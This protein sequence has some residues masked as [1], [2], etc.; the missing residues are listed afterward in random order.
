[1]ENSNQ[2][3]RSFLDSRHTAMFDLLEKL[4]TTQSGSHNVQGVNR[5]GRRVAEVFAD[6]AFNVSTVSGKGT[7]DHLV[8]AAA[9]VTGNGRR[10]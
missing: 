8:A 4:V 1:M 3:I 9:P 5:M 6:S 2:R 10:Y 7:G